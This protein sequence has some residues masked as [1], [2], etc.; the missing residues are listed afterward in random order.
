MQLAA[1]LM[2]MQPSIQPAAGRIIINDDAPLPPGR[3][4]DPARTAASH[5][6]CREILRTDY[7]NQLFTCIG[8]VR[9][10]RSNGIKIGGD[11]LLVVLREMMAS[12]ELY[13]VRGFGGR[14]FYKFSAAT[15]TIQ[16]LSRS[17]ATFQAKTTGAINIA[18]HWPQAKTGFTCWAFSRH[19]NSDRYAAQAVKTM[20]A[21]GELEI[22]ESGRRTVYRLKEKQQEQ[23]T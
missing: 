21:N 3:K 4:S 1:A 16:V 6:K 19:I 8:V 23:A 11:Q 5:E 10:C 18:R 17:L 2:G 14:W 22:I 13:R 20:L 9:Q 12:G 15:G 7:F